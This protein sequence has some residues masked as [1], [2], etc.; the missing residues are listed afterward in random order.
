MHVHYLAD[1]YLCTETEI[2]QW[3]VMT[4]VKGGVEVT[5][6][7]SGRPVSAG[8]GGRSWLWRSDRG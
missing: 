3:W 7:Y 8:Y 5:K 6:A 4:G 2:P 1:C